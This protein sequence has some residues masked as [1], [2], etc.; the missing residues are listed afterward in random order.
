MTL[1]I[2]TPSETVLDSLEVAAVFLPGTLGEFEV[3]PHHASIISSLEKGRLRYR[4]PDGKEDS[5][6]VAS[7]FVT[8]AGDVIKACVEL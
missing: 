3:L 4:T 1:S 7:G 2:L 5:L 6:Q 8:V